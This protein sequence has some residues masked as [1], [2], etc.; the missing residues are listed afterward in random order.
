MNWLYKHSWTLVAAIAVLYIALGAIAADARADWY[1][2]IEL[3]AVRH[4]MP[5]DGV[6]WQ[7]NQP[8]SSTMHSTTYAI[9]MGVE[10]GKAD[11]RISYANLGKQEI[12]TIAVDDNKFTPSASP[13]PEDP[14]YSFYTRGSETG[15]A[16]EIATPRKARSIYGSLSA[17]L[18]RPDINIAVVHPGG[19]F[20][21]H[22]ADGRVVFSP[23]VAI[24][25]QFTKNAAVVVRHYRLTNNAGFPTPTN[26]ATALSVNVNF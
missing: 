1:T 14:T 11:L 3:G 9:G 13:N 4:T 22:K 23:A 20:S 24:G 19:S 21:Q 16:L 10:L 12:E 26:G 8:H 7:S 25:W 2:T 5:V 17:F 15:L 18:Y 6:Y